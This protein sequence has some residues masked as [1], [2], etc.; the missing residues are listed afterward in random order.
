MQL[1]YPFNEFSNIEPNPEYSHLELISASQQATK[2][3]EGRTRS[4]LLRLSRYYYSSVLLSVGVSDHECRQTTTGARTRADRS[5]GAGRCALLPF[6]M[7]VSK[8]DI[9]AI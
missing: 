7:A 2:N 4:F 5:A 1:L 6:D 9:G 3:S 8:T